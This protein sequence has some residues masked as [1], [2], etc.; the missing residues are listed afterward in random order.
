MKKIILF[1]IIFLIL[2]FSFIGVAKAVD[3]PNASSYNC[4]DGK[5]CLSDPLGK[6]TP[7]TLIGRVINAILGLVGSIA[8]AMFI[9]GGFTWMTAGG[10]AE[11]VKKGRDIILW[12]AIGLV[13]IFSAYALVNFVFT[14]IGV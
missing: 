8:L 10:N 14:S 13:V 3:P 4:P 2:I 1:L 6:T 12:A 11:N 5:V 9:W 7:Q